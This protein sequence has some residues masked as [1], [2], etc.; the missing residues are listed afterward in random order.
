MTQHELDSAVAQ[1]TGESIDTIAARGFS[2]VEMD[3]PQPVRFS[4]RPRMVD[5]DAL[6]AERTSYLPQ[7][8]RIVVV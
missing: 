6:D 1:A 3:V 4:K 7:R 8:R 2:L 5:W